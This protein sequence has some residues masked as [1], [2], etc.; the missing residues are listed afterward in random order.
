MPVVIVF[1]ERDP[2]AFHRVSNDSSG[3]VAAA[4]LLQFACD[5]LNV[6][7]IDLGSIPS[8]SGPLGGERFESH[9]LVTA[10]GGLPLVVVDDYR[11]LPEL[12]GRRKQGRFPDR[13]FV[14]FAIA[15]RNK[16]AI[17]HFP[18]PR[19]QSQ[20]YPDWKAVT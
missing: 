6:V 18:G 3:L 10:A 12:L 19:R 5:R 17:I 11:Q 15:H 8:E 14:A 13:A 16:D 1:H 2:F 7:S 4:R 20:T 9:D